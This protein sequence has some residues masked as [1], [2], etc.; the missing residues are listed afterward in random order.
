MKLYRL[1]IFL[2]ITSSFLI[3]TACGGGGGGSIGYGE[4]IVHMTD[5]KPLLPE[6]AENVTNLWITIAGVSVHKSG[7]GWISLP[8]EQGPPHT[9]DLLQLINGNT[10]EI[11]PPVLLEYGKYT[12]IRLIVD[13]ATIRF[14]NEPTTDASVVIPPEHLKTDKNFL[15]DVNEPKA[16]DIVIDFDLSQSLVLTDPFGTPSYKINPVIHIVRAAEATTIKGEISQGSFIVGQNAEVTLFIPNSGIQGG[17]AE[18]TKIEVSESG[19]DPTGFSIYWL[20]PDKDY[21]VEIKFD[22]DFVNGVNFSEDVS[23]T[24]VKPGKVWNLNGGNSI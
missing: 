16:V 15:F 5:A 18:Y 19:T 12:Q 9:I 20:V 6:G 21:R 3:I 10:I 1:L 2:T 14:D 7:G 8:L 13:S 17:Y 11:V 22:P 24:D 4:V 23:A